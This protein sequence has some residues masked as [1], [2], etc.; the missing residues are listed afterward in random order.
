MPEEAKRV[1]QRKLAKEFSR[2]PIKRDF[3]KYAVIRKDKDGSISEQII[4]NFVINIKASFY[5]E[6]GIIRHVELV[7]EFG[8]KS[9]TFPMEAGVM[10]GVNEFKSSL[11]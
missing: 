3:N 9:N 10:A 4:S 11:Q 5:T 6:E 2:V 8:E 1:V 7:N